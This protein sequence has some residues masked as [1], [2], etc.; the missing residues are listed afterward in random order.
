MDCDQGAVYG[1]EYQLQCIGNNGG[2][3]EISQRLCQICPVNAHT[4]RERTPYASLSGPVEAEY[5][6]E[7]TAS[8]ITSLPVTRCGVTTMSW[9]QN[10]SP[11]SGD[12]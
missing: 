2:K 4:G 11:W 3:I 9:S 8:W 10:G 12:I 5:E 6:D 1:A 7:V